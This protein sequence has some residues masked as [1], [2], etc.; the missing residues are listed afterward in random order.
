[1]TGAEVKSIRESLRLNQ[2]QFAQLLGVHSLT[3]SK[4]E[5]DILSVQPHHN[6]LI[7]SF[8]RA[9]SAT[10]GVGDEVAKLLVTAG[11][12]VAIFVLLQAAFKEN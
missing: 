7:E 6:A 12:V 3:V 9:K 1:M 10:P 4:W 11:V 8:K 5:R 2:A